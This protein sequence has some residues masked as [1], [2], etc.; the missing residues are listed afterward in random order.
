MSILT[1]VLLVPYSLFV[2]LLVP[3][4][5]YVALLVPFSL[6]A[7]GTGSHGGETTGANM[8]A[9]AGARALQ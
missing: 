4:S 5:L 9:A 8:A 7:A 6:H 3:Y 2:A 1:L